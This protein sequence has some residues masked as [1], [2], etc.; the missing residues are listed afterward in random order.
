MKALKISLITFG[1][2]FVIVYLAFLL[3]IPAFV[4]LEDYNYELNNDKNPEQGLIIKF[5]NVRVS[6]TWNLSAGVKVG[7]INAFYKSG[8]KFAQIDNIDTTISLPYLVFKKIKIN[9]IAIDKIITRLSV[10][11][12][13]HFT[14]ENFIPSQD[15]NF[16]NT[17]TTMVLPYGLEFSENMPDKIK[18]KYSITFIDNITDKHYALKGSNFKVC[19]FI[20]NEKIKFKAIGEMLLDKRKQISYDLDLTSLVMPDFT[21]VSQK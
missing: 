6:T 13:G 14:I 11:K 3:A 2:L 19:D 18:K 5:E 21:N 4:K 17:Q 9:K 7:Q 16:Q 10:E 1:S 8:E 15:K 12:D 20:L